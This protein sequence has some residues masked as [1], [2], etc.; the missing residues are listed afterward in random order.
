MND[1]PLWFIRHPWCASPI[2]T[3]L[4]FFEQLQGYSNR[5][6]T[7]LHLGE[8]RVPM[9]SRAPIDDKY[10]QVMKKYT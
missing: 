5:G 3:W 2:C 6:R 9:G 10:S 7:R 1:A 4:M 8:A